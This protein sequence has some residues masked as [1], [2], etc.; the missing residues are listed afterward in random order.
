MNMA[1]LVRPPVYRPGALPRSCSKEDGQPK[2]VYLHRKAARRAARLI[3]PDRP[4]IQAYRCRHADHYHVG[5]RRTW[6]E[7]MPLAPAQ[8]VAIR[9]LA[10]AGEPH[11]AIARA[12]SIPVDLVVAIAERRVFPRATDGPMRCARCRKVD[13]TV[14]QT[15]TL[16]GTRWPPTCSDCSAK[17]SRIRAAER[18]E[19]GQVDA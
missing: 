15:I 4:G 18:V 6:R 10:A 16:D 3:R 9:R 14:S 12:Y 5:H 1:V 2:V 13:G 8:A 7:E 19:L 11:E 17:A